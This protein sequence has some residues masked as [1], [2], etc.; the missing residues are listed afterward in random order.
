MV[1][2]PNRFYYVEVALPK[3]N[4]AVEAMMARAERDAI[5]PRVLVKEAVIAYYSDSPVSTP[6]T[7]SRTKATRR[8]TRKPRPVTNENVS[9]AAFSSADAFLDDEGF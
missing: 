9:E 8:S 1:R 5:A 7:R 3:G 6:T 2:D 4:E